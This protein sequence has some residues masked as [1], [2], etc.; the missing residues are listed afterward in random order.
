MGRPL[1][2]NVENGIYHVYARGNDRG[3]IFDDDADRLA[4]LR[5][6]GKVSSAMEWRCLA[7][8]LMTNHVHLLLETP[9][10]NLS[11]GMQRLQSSYTKAFNGRRQRTGHLFGSR[12]GSTLV[13]SDEQLAAVA[14]YIDDNPIE[15]G[16]CDRASDWP[17]SSAYAQA[18][19]PSPPWLDS[20][21]LRALLKGV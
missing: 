3:S 12:F 20:A 7:F 13:E 4:Y 1:R 9:V 10:G 11:R 19:G 14:K 8:C 2:L 15:A 6:L 17:W 21:R 16:I 5:L 18:V